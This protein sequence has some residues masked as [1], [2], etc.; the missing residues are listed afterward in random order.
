MIAVIHW[1]AAPASCDVRHLVNPF[2]VCEGS[3]T[4]LLLLQMRKVRR[5]QVQQLAKGTK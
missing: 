3:T 1:G 5:G 4:I 2:T